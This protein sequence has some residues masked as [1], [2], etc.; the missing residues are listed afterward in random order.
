MGSKISL[1]TPEEIAVMRESCRCTAQ[2]L[3]EVGAIVKPGV[4]TE[5]INT[6][7][8]RRTSALGAVPSPLNYKGYPKSV[9]TSVNDVV[10]HGEPARLHDERVAEAERRTATDEF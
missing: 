10:C 2:I 6:F 3:D 9:C 4:S 5:D 7:V 8:H 1:K